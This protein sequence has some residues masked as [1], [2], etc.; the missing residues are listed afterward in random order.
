MFVRDILAD[1]GTDVVTVGPDMT[2]SD[3]AAVLVDNK[4][5]AVVVV[6]DDGRVAG[7]ISERD[8]I[9]GIAGHGAGC[10]DLKVGALMSADVISCGPDT[11]I[12][13]VMSRMTERRIRHLPVMD[14]DALIGV[15]SIGDVVKKRIAEAER[16]NNQL[17]QY[18]TA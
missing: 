15:V 9:H 8:V 11:T 13:E 5:G 4:I 1:K 7:V 3:Y 14:G 16:E 10:L 18:I 6:G 17:R 2:I 12:H